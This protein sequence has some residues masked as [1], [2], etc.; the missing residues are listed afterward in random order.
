MLIETPRLPLYK[1]SFVCIRNIANLVILCKKRSTLTLIVPTTSYE[2]KGKVEE[3][4]PETLYL[5]RTNIHAN[6]ITFI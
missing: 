4:E 6:T 5:M 1:Q 2:K 3:A